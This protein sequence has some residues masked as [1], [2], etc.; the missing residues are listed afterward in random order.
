MF[1]KQ[2]KTIES[3]RRESAQHIIGYL[4]TTHKDNDKNHSHGINKKPIFFPPT[5]KISNYSPR[6]ILCDKNPNC[7]KN[8]KY[9]FRSY[10]QA[11]NKPN[12]M[13]T[14]KART[15]DGIYLRYTDSHQGGHKI[16]H[17]QTNKIITKRNITTLPINDIIN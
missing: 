2:N 14:N 1:W 16:I 4:F 8:C 6:M 17:L 9:S 11:H 12:P 10:V 13:N 5:N 15:L 3:S 7:K